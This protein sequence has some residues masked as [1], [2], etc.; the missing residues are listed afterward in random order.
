MW[1]CFP[2]IRAKRHLQQRTATN[3]HASDQRQCSRIRVTVNPSSGTFNI[4]DSFEKIFWGNLK[5]KS[6]GSIH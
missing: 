1:I 3:I 2:A 5:Q 6:S 4:L